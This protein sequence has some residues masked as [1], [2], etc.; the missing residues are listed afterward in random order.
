MTAIMRNSQPTNRRKDTTYYNPKPKEKFDLDN[1]SKLYRIRGTIGGDRIH[2]LGDTKANT[3]AMPVVKMLLQSTIS[4][5]A[6]WMTIDIKDFY[7]NTLLPRSEYLSI[8]LKF[9]SPAML[10]KYNLK[11]YVDNG[12]VLFEVLRSMYGLP[13]AGRIAQ[14]ALILHLASHQYTYKPRLYVSS[15]NIPPTARISSLSS[16]TSALSIAQK[17]PPS[18]ASTAF[19]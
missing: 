19:N 13:H 18:T 2:Y 1:T 10:I 5:D 4:E 8:P 12:H 6:Q 11:P 9:L 7:L 15:S 17:T 16:M 14:E 3:A